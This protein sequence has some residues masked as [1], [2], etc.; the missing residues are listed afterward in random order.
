MLTE[1][2]SSLFRRNEIHPLFYF[3]K[4]FYIFFFSLYP[5]CQP[6]FW[7]KNGQEQDQGTFFFV[8]SQKLLSLMFSL[9]ELGPR[10]QLCLFLLC[11]FLIPSGPTFLFYLSLSCPNFSF[12]LNL[13]AAN[14]YSA[15]LLAIYS[16]AWDVFPWPWRVGGWAEAIITGCVWGLLRMVGWPWYQANGLACPQLLL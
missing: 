2:F 13:S 3:K 16:H 1:T 7:F 12:L 6:L 5:E 10:S 15:L 8:W 4:K 14:L 9:F 11:Y